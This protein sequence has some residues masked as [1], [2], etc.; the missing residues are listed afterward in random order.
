MRPALKLTL[1]LLLIVLLA[2]AYFTE[3]ELNIIDKA[4]AGKTIQHEAEFVAMIRNACLSYSTE[5]NRLP[6][7]SDNKRL[8]AALTGENARHISFLWLSQ[9]QLNSNNEMIDHWGT[10]LKIIFQ[11]TSGIQITS[12]GPDKIFGTADDIVTNPTFSR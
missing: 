2:F 3:R 5:Y 11:G 8:T 10:P 1:A 12:A 4:L 9:S 7:D 6:P